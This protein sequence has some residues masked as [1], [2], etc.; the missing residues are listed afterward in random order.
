M[1]VEIFAWA[2]LENRLTRKYPTKYKCENGFVDV[3]DFLDAISI[4]D[5]SDYIN[6]RKKDCDY[7]ER[8]NADIKESK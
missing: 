7:V 6:L 1:S 5:L 3:I 2:E 4:A 8:S